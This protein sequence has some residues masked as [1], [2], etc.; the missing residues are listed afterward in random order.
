VV[1]DTACNILLYCECLK[2]HYNANFEAITKLMHKYLY[3]YD[4]TI[5]YMF[6]ALLWYMYSIKLMIASKLIS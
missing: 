2:Q 6:R 3:S 1:N 5:L 4:I